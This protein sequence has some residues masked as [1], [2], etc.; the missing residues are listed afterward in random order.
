MTPVP[1]Q[2]HDD[3]ELSEH[4]VV[5]KRPARGPLISKAEPD[6][7]LRTLVG[8]AVALLGFICIASW[9]SNRELGEMRT[10]MR[11]STEATDRRITSLENATD[12]RITAL[13]RKVWGQ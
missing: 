3:S 9:N 11:T 1:D 13:E 7:L 8:C 4:I 2:E 5:G 10:E 12:R 6:F